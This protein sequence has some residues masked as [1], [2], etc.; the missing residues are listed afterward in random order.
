MPG[1]HN[2]GGIS[3]KE[4]RPGNATA[5]T[6]PQSQSAQKPHKFSGTGWHSEWVTDCTCRGSRDNSSQWWKWPEDVL[7]LWGLLPFCHHSTL[8]SACLC[9]NK[10]NLV[11]SGC[12][13]ETAVFTE[14]QQIR[15]PGQ[16][17]LKIQQ[18]PNSLEGGREA[19][20]KAR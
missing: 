3:S 6:L 14:R 7:E 17:V 18:L 15:R 13:K 8:G 12:V 4:H 20:L 16:L 2:H 5:T 10:A 9:S 11:T 1:V 19:R